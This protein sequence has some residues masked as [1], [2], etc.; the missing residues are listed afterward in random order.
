MIGKKIKKAI[1]EKAILNYRVVAGL[2]KGEVWIVPTDTLY[3]IVTTT[4]RKKSVERVYRLRNR[5][6]KK[7]CIILT[8]SIEDIARMGVVVSPQL[9]RFLKKIWPGSVSV[10]LK[11]SKKTPFY[12]HRGTYSLAFRIPRNDALRKLIK[13]TGPLIA[14]SANPQ[15]ALPA[16]S[17]SEAITYFGDLVDGYVIGKS[18]NKKPSTLISWNE[19]RLVL[20]RKGVIAFSLLKQKV[21]E[22]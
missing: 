17:A 6:Y 20:L 21:K 14:P 2:Q 22:F 3:G 16:R 11:V 9:Y 8:A 12:L 15:G 4:L 10:V 5:D 19:G 13:K 18:Q 7:P 1:K